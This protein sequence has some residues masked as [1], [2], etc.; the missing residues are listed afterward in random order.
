MAWHNHQSERGAMARSW[1]R[2]G[3]EAAIIQDD[4]K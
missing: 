2:H 1:L 3:Y 4:I